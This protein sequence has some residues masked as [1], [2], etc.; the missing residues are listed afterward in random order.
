M[1]E[2]EPRR[3]GVYVVTYAQNATP[4]DDNFLASLLVYCKA[5]GGE[6]VVIPGRYRNPTSRWTQHNESDEWW[7]PR[8][9]PYVYRGQLEI[10]PTLIAYGNVPIQPTAVTPLSGLEACCGAASA[11]FGHPKIQL[12]TIPGE[13]TDSARVMTTTGAVTVPNYTDSKAGWKGDLHH[14][15]GA[16]VVEVD[17]DDWHLRQINADASG[18]FYDLD[19]HYSPDGVE[20]A[21]PALGLVLG[22]VH[23]AQVDPDVV[24][25]TLRAPDSMAATLRPRQVVYHDL[26][27]FR[28]RNHH[29]IKNPDGRYQRAVGDLPDSVEAEV[30]EAIAFLDATPDGCDPIVVPSNHDEAFDRWLREADPNVDPVNA[31]F[32]HDTRAS[33]LG[34]YDR[35]G[36]WPSALA[37][38]YRLRGGGRARFID[39]SEPFKIAGIAC[40]FHGDKGPGGSRGTIAGYAK[41]GV[42]TIIGHGHGPGI[43]DGCTQVGVSGQLNMGY[44]AGAPSSW[45][46]AH[47]VIYANG[48]R[49]LIFI[50][51]GRWRARPEVEAERAAA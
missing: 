38:V 44:N 36:V 4:V 10:A 18:A 32:Y 7:D 35:T 28:A 25:A 30:L 9:A 41:L 17:G 24:E 33:V 46:H 40:N 13:D 45:A 6:L 29:E 15:T 50:K 12:T 22:D 3:S 20:A 47:C 42:K 2:V 31:R 48:K 23:V 16:C 27:D 43:R 26:L 14:V 1:P 19:R 39:R 51:R 5:R 21:P 11:I 37:L 49:S 8:I 34:E